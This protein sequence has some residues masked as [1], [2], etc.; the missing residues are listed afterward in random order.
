M[1]E[2]WHFCSICRKDYFHAIKTPTAQIDDW[3]RLCASCAFAASQTMTSD[4]YSAALGTLRRQIDQDDVSAMRFADR[5]ATP[6]IT[7][8]DWSQI[9]AST[10]SFEEEFDTM[11][12]L[13]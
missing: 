1:T 10:A 6:G 2:C 3:Q 9:S 5:F 13:Q 11:C 7:K 4:T 12:F 8:A